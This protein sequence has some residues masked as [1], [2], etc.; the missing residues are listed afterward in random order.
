MPQG[1]AW[2][3]LVAVAVTLVLLLTVRKK[4]ADKND[5]NDKADQ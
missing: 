1:I 4:P 5:N 3:P 2:F